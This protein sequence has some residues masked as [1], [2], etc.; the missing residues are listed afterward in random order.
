MAIE[1]YVEMMAKT[2]D[3]HFLA[4]KRIEDLL[5]HACPDFLCRYALVTHTLVPY[6]VCMTIGEAQQRVLDAILPKEAFDK[7]L[8]VEEA[9]D[10]ARARALVDSILVPVLKKHG[11]NAHAMRDVTRE[12]ITK[13]TGAKEAE[14]A[15]L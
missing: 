15:K 10:E 7:G 8:T 13:Q 5:A 1:N 11:V 6:A 4:Q 12:I 2:A 14:T 3:P 9:F